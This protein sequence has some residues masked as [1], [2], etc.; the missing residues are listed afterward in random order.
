MKT[1]LRV[2]VTT[3]DR[4]MWA[5]QPFVYL[6]NRYWDEQQPVVVAGYSKPSFELPPNFEFYQI[7]EENHPNEKWSDGVIKFLEDMDDELFIWLLEDFW[8]RCAADVE[9]VNALVEY[10]R[11]HK[12]I[13]KIDLTTGRLILGGKPDQMPGYE[14]C[15]DLELVWSNPWSSFHLSLQ[16]AIWRREQLLRHMVPG[17]TPQCFEGGPAQERLSRTP[18]MVVL[19]TRHFLVKYAHVAV[20]SQPHKSGMAAL[21][22]EDLEELV[23][24]GWVSEDMLT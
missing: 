6:F 24:R 14:R 1:A 9:T 18:G 16:A 7:A 3:N 20:Y 5:L 17:E 10:M 12:E 4:N 15:G 8:L 19:G 11:H 23:R 2:F 22:R 21:R 13:I